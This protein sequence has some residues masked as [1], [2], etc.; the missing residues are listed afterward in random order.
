MGML[1]GAVRAGTRKLRK[2]VTPEAEQLDLTSGQTRV[3]P[4]TE[5]QRVTGNLAERARASGTGTGRIQGG[6]TVG[7]A[8]LAAEAARQSMDSDSPAAADADINLDNRINPADFPTY[9]KGSKSAKAFRAAFAKAVKDGEKTFKFEGREYNTKKL[10]KKL[11][12]DMPPPKPKRKPVQKAQGGMAGKKPRNAN[13]D[14][15]KKG[16]FYVGGTSAKVTPINKG[17]K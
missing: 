5:A 3:K 15:R 11:D 6:A 7:G 16:M 12:V 4:A 17:K 8:A 14:Y 2:A 10:A 1:S 13:I 9:R